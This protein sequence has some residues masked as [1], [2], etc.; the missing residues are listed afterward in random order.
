MCSIPKRRFPR[1]TFIFGGLYVH[2]SRRRE[3][4]SQKAKPQSGTENQKAIILPY[5]WP[6][7]ESFLSPGTS[8]L[9]DKKAKCEGHTSRKYA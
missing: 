5:F 8:Y 2:P 6:P 1:P 3:K 4:A 9:D 7:Q